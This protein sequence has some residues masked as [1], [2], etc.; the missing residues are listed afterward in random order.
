MGLTETL[1]M[2]T[3]LSV[4]II[5]YIV[6][7]L[8]DE[9]KKLKYYNKKFTYETDWDKYSTMVVKQNK[10]LLKKKI[11]LLYYKILVRLKRVVTW[12]H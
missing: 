8:L 1:L 10:I 12:K 3:I 5:M 4:V 7:V 11:E 2:I 6:Y 9:R